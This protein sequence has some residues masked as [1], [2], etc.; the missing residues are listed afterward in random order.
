MLLMTL[1]F[2]LCKL[3]LGCFFIGFNSFVVLLKTQP[4]VLF[5]A[6]LFHEGLHFFHH[7]LSFLSSVK[8]SMNCVFPN[9]VF[10][11]H[12]IGLGGWL[13]IDWLYFEYVIV[14]ITRILNNVIFTCV[15]ICLWE[16]TVVCC[17]CKI[18]IVIIII[19]LCCSQID[20]YHTSF[21]L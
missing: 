6:Y 10:C 11:I 13:S 5:W 15:N 12:M 16:P 19:I 21:S 4:K 1:F 3:F 14:F 18:Q 2:L 7:L 9:N 17:D 20:T 8:E